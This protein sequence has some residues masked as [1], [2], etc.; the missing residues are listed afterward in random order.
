MTP[1]RGFQVKYPKITLHA[2]SRSETGPYIYCQ[3]DEQPDGAELAED[4]DSEMS[5]LKIF[6]GDITAGMRRL[7]PAPCF[8]ILTSFDSG[9][10]IRSALPM[11]VV[12]PGPKCIRH[13][14]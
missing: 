2:V 4:E 1:S 3:L 13:R 9:S 7:I 8:S 11:R 10:H 14:A 5:E 6:P 12:A